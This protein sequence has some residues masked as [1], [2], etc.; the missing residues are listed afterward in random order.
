VSSMTHGEVCDGCG[1]RAGVHAFKE[2]VRVRPGQ[3]YEA[4]CSCGWVSPPENSSEG[5]LS[6]VRDHVLTA[7]DCPCPQKCHRGTHWPPDIGGPVN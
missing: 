7:E 6:S 5:A 4:A 2:G 1:L 3:G